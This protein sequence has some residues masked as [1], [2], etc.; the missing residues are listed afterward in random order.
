[1]ASSLAIHLLPHAAQIEQQIAPVR[2]QPPRHFILLRSEFE[3]VALLGEP[4]QLFVG[5]EVA[6]IEL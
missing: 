3:I 4:R 5:A 1:M 6:G 2:P